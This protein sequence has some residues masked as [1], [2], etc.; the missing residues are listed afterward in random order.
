MSR[1]TGSSAF[2]D[3]DTEC[4]VA[5]CLVIS[6]RML[7]VSGLIH[8]AAEFALVCDLQL[9]KPRLAGGIRIDQRRLG[10]ERAVDFQYFARNRRVDVGC[11][12]DRFDYGGGFRLLQ[13]AADLGQFDEHDV[14]ELRLRIIGDADGGDV[15]LDAEPFMVGGVKRRHFGSFSVYRCWERRGWLR[16]AAAGAVRAIRRI[17][18]G[19]APNAKRADSPWR[20][21]H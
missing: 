21:A 2:A 11:R 1:R 9:E 12:L 3:D 5:A 4:G 6:R 16:P 8:Q 10:C 15:A 20:P 18:N 19:R 17:P 7:G 14:A 13:A